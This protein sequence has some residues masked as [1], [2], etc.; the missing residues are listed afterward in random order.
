MLNTE[1]LINHWLSV[2][3]GGLIERFERGLERLFGM[4]GRRD[5]V[6]LSVEA[7]L[8][9]DLA[10][11]A[12]ALAKMVQG[13]VMK[14]D[15]ARKHIGE[16]PADGGDQLLVQRQMVP[17]AIA[18]DLANAE[19]EKLTAPPPPPPRRRFHRR[20]VT[21]ATAAPPCRHRHHPSPTPPRAKKPRGNSRSNL[22]RGRK[23]DTRA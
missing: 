12:E 2:S 23:H 3:L 6:D 17:L 8:R 22:S 9:T 21:A 13:G 7:L 15:E 1:A 11:Q 5:Y 4:D 14:P 16:G 20:T 18:A 10:S 19:L